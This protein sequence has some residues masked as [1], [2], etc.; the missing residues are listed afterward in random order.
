ME[1]LQRVSSNLKQKQK[2]SGL[3]QNQHWSYMFLGV[4]KIREGKVEKKE[5]KKE[6]W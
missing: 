6:V 1:S 2:F 3:L 4:G 5:K